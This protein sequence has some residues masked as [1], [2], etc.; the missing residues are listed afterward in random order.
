MR[1]DEVAHML[2]AAFWSIG[3]S[4]DE[5]EMGAH[6]SALVLGAFT[7]DNKQI[8]YARVISDKI[9]FAYITDVIVHED[10][11]KTG[12]GQLMIKN[13]LSAEELKDVYQW[14]L[15]TKDAH[16]VYKKLGFSVT[17]RP[18]DWMEIKRPRPKR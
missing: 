18:N 1:F 14:V 8:G 5:V 11:R 10:Y 3:I 2:S 16:E 12:I 17:A 6:N 4:Q 9:R 13:I 15:I 7:G